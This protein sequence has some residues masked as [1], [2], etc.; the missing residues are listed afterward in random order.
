MEKV[1]QFHVVMLQVYQMGFLFLFC[2]NEQ[3]QNKESC[4]LLSLN[5]TEFSY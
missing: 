3:K 5:Q 2:P 1:K 4:H